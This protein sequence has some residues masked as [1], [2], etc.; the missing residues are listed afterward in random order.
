M[1]SQLLKQLLNA[2][3]TFGYITKSIR[4]QIGLEKS[5]ANDAF[6]AAQGTT[7][8]RAKTKLY[9]FKRKNN[10]QLATES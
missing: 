7:Q 10:R 9:L 2:E 8:A 6:I 5:H 4:L 1:K 3:E